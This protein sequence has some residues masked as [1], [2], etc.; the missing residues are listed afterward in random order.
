MAKNNYGKIYD[1]ITITNLK[2]FIEQNKFRFKSIFEFIEMAK[3]QYLLT[4]DRFHKKVIKVLEE[5]KHLPDLPEGQTYQLIFDE[6]DNKKA[7]GK[8]LIDKYYENELMVQF[9]TI[10]EIPFEIEF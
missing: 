9:E 8:I 7:I 5:Y 1:A 2:A 10:Q 6:Y 3:L 4:N